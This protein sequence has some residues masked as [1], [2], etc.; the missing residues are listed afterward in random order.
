[1]QATIYMQALGVLPTLI[2][3]TRHW[4]CYILATIKPFEGRTFLQMQGVMP[5]A[6]T[7]KALALLLLFW[8]KTQVTY[9]FCLVGKEETNLFNK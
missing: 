1:M 5:A 3:P 6:W 2:T 7:C 8:T 4:K 9:S